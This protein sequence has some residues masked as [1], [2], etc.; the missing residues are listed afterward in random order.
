[1]AFI[2]LCC[3]TYCGTLVQ[4]YNFSHCW[5]SPSPLE[6]FA[7]NC[8]MRLP[9]HG[10]SARILTC[11]LVVLVFFSGRNGT[12]NWPRWSQRSDQL[13]AEQLWSRGSRQFGSLPE[14]GCSIWGL[15]R[16]LSCGFVLHKVAFQLSGFC[17]CSRVFRWL[18]NAVESLLWVEGVVWSSGYREVEL[19]TCH[20]AG[21]HCHL[22][23]GM[24]WWCP[25][26]L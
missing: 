18:W 5:S 6:R 1:M 2:F 3:V 9:C 21:L 24:R 13:R 15:G 11:T 16:Y 7:W 22:G 12:R 26:S 25:T 14:R 19:V 17:D 10:Y 8:C 4:L 20:G 23:A